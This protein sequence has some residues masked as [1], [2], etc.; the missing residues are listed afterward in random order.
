MEGFR[1]LPA[2]NVADVMGRSPAMNLRIHLISRPDRPVMVGAAL[3]VKARAGDNLLLHKALDMAQEGDVIVVSNEEDNTRSLMGEI[4][5]I[6][7]ANTRKAAGIVL[8]GPIRDV[9]VIREMSFPVYAT[10][11]TP[12]GPYK[13]GPGEINVPIACGG[14]QVDPGDIILGDADGVIVIPREDAGGV[15][16]QARKYHAL[17]DKK[18]Q[19]ARDGASDRSWVDR[20]IQTKGVEI[21]DDYWS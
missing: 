13:E 16:E 18:C 14:I 1:E 20:S 10:G 19:A 2:A 21:I 6:Y 4:M 15:L 17:D 9:D 5:M 11:S 7:L 3:T 12:N 8:D